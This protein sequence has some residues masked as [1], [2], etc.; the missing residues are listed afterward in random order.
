MSA[1]NQSG[2]QG[3][4]PS[5]SSSIVSS[6]TIPVA[7]SPGPTRRVVRRVMHAPSTT[8]TVPATPI[9]EEKPDSSSVAPEDTTSPTAPEAP[10]DTPP[11]SSVRRIVCRSASYVPSISE[12]EYTEASPAQKSRLPSIARESINPLEAVHAKFIAQWFAENMGGD[13]T[14]SEMIQTTVEENVVGTD[15]SQSVLSYIRSRLRES[16]GYDAYDEFQQPESGTTA[17]CK[18]S[19]N[20]IVGL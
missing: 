16:T 18:K 8:G 4:V 12:T 6:N 19:F 1:P 2:K 5:S 14:Y 13:A 9:D 3:N 15:F 20:E 11:V 7:P 17:W 10:V